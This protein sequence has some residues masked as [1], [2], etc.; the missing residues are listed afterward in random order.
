VRL[1]RLEREQVV[2][3]P[4]S[5]VFEFFVRAEN[6]E[7]ITPPWL[8][9]RMLTPEPIEMGVG[10]LID[11]RLRLH[12]LPL[13]W[14]SRIELWEQEHRFVDEQLHGPYRFWR[15]LHE[16]VPVDGGT[17]VRDRVEYALPL[18][19]LGEL[20]GLPVVRRDLVRIF[21]YRRGTVARLLG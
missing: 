19:P 1:Q 20:L 5:E 7:R 18:G 3:R 14:T 16:F 8:R 4:L 9:F 10:T 2:R 21:D 17:C 12:G 13:R 15:H 6:L 11:Y